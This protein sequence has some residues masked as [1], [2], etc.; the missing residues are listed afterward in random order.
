MEFIAPASHLSERADEQ[1]PPLLALSKIVSVFG[2][3]QPRPDGRSIPK[4]SED[5]SHTPELTPAR[6]QAVTP[7]RLFALSSRHST[8]R[9]VPVCPGG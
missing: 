8:L 2:F 5:A 6:P 9:T 1:L 4:Q 3:A 7:K